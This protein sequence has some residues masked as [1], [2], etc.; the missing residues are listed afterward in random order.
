VVPQDWPV[1]VRPQ[2][3]VSVSVA[4]TV[5]QVPLLHTASVRVRVRLPVSL[6]WPA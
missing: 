3:E 1:V 6:H 4:V 2:A 5:P